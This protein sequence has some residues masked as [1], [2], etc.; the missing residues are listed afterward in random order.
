MDIFMT[1]DEQ[2]MLL[3]YVAT[4]PATG[5]IVE[6]G[7]GGSTVA[8][9]KHM[10]EGV[11]FRSVEHSEHWY[12]QI[13]HELD[14][15]ADVCLMLVPPSAEF[16]AFARQEEEDPTLLIDYI[17]T[18]AD[19]STVDLF[20]VDGVARTSCLDRVAAEGKT[21]CIALLHDA[22][23]DWYDSARAKFTEVEAVGRLVA[24][25]LIRE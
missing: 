3:R 17:A 5:S 20:L 2:E 1:A 23:R 12:N 11:D 6:W 21:D 8:I 7:A 19:I 9:S 13:E 15:A 14:D 4:V 10:H 24:L 25:K 16:T 22:E 18:P